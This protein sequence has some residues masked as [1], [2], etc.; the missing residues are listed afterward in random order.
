MKIFKFI[1]LF[2]LFVSTLFAD[3]KLYLPSHTL[4]KNEAFIFVLEAYGNDIT[5]PNISLID[6][7]IV[8]EVA[9]SNSTNIINGNITKQIKKT[10]SFY[11]TKDFI[12][13]SFETIIDGKSYKTNEEKISNFF[14]AFHCCRGS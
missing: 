14:K 10:Y 5:F 7:Q 2:F 8:Q 12:L 13:P 9:S 3:V 4:V 1:S 6:G 11:P